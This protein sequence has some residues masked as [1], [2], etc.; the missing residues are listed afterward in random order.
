MGWLTRRRLSFRRFVAW[1]DR[2]L[3][4]AFPPY[5]G[6]ILSIICFIPAWKLAP[7]FTGWLSADG[8]IMAS[9]GVLTLL[10]PFIRNGG[11]YGWLTAN[12]KLK[13]PTEEEKQKKLDSKAINIWGPMLTI[14]GTML[15]GVSGY[16]DF[17]N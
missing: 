9:F 2:K 14:V 8:A 16:F 13:N 15:N 6:L 17:L 12:T 1:A 3:A 11:Y 7:S 10:R 5:V 4:W